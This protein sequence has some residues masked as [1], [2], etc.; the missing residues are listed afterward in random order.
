MVFQ[1]LWLGLVLAFKYTHTTNPSLD[2]GVE[3][4]GERLGGSFSK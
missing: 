2:A 3:I 4:P 1:V